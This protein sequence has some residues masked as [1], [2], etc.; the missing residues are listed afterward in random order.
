MSKHMVLWAACAALLGLAGMATAQDNY[1]V[2]NS[3]SGALAAGA[4]VG[5]GFS[6]PGM[7]FGDVGHV[8]GGDVGGGPGCPNCGFGVNGAY[9]DPCWRGPCID[10]KL[11]GWYSHW[12]HTHHCARGNAACGYEG[13][14]CAPCGN[15]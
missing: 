15:H 6:A 8:M 10:W 1:S 12:G 4:Q 9:C 3:G 11:I 13:G 2:Y 7:R 5:G 14:A